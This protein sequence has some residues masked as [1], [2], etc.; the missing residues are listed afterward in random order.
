M[1]EDGVLRRPAQ[2]YRNQ[3]VT[4]GVRTLGG[5]ET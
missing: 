1:E 2:G 5:P 4:V 3:T